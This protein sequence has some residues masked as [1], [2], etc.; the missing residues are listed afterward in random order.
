MGQAAS[1]MDCCTSAR[2]TRPGARVRR[3]KDAPINRGR[4]NVMQRN[5]G[6]AVS[7]LKSPGS[8]SPTSSRGSPLMS[9]RPSIT[10]EVD[11]LT[12]QLHELATSPKRPTVM[13]HVQA[14]DIRGASSRTR[15]NRPLAFAQPPP[16]EPIVC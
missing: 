14:G 12:E 13:R 16:V 10:E 5:P 1:T 8:Q 6:A 3:P 9:S 4:P 11:E 2:E 7:P 15:P